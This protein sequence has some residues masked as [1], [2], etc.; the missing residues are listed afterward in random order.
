MCLHCYFFDIIHLGT[1]LCSLVSVYQYYTKILVSEQIMNVSPWQM[2][3]LV[4][5][6]YSMQP[7]QFLRN[8]E[9]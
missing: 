1:F 2:F 6:T 7:L 3:G 4:T 9:C 5:I 8:S